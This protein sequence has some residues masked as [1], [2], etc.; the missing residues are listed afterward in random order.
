MI[1]LGGFTRAVIDGLLAQR[2]T[3][4]GIIWLSW[5]NNWQK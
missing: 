1:G 3:E 4:D 2:Q 5:L